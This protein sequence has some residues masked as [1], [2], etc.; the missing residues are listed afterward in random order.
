MHTA[1][2]L[3]NMDGLNLRRAPRHHTIV[4]KQEPASPR[5]TMLRDAAATPIACA[6]EHVEG[7]NVMNIGC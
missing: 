2:S 5:F 4:C 7:D 3:A 1:D 6:V